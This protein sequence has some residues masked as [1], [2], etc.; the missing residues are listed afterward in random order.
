ML[1]DALS[2][3]AYVSPGNA[4][5]AKCPRTLINLQQ[6]LTKHFRLDLQMGQVL[7]DADTSIP[8]PELGKRGCK[9]RVMQKGINVT[10]LNYNISDTCLLFSR[11]VV[12][13]LL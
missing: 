9:K 3:I 8:Q 5:T 10:A 6:A 13:V 4:E 12:V 7:A 2:R 11:Q 1:V